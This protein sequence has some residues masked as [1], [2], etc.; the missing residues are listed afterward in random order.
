[1]PNRFHLKFCFALLFFLS[2]IGYSNAQDTIITTQGD[3]LECKITRV[4][5]EFIHFSV[6]DRSGVLLMRSRIPISGV[7]SYVQTETDSS[8]NSD[9]KNEE[10]DPSFYEQR[11]PDFVRLAISSG[12]TYQFGGYEGLPQTYVSKITSLWNIG[13]ELHLFTSENFGIG[14]KYNRIATPVSHQFIP[15]LITFFDTISNIEED[16][17]FSYLALSLMGRQILDN[18]NHIIYFEA[19]GGIVNYNDNGTIDGTSFFESGDAFGL[20]LGVGYD[21]AINSYFGLGLKIE[22]NLATLNSLNL[23]G[24]NVTGTDFNVSRIDFTAG[25]R[26]YR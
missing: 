24:T 4:T 13:A 21:Y 11:E 10:F 3:T 20:A 8:D 12:Y 18:P 2:L 25:I 9:T 22:V 1:M 23:N 16:V 7:T 19:S 14:L 17:R 26:F 6:F 5:D 15:P